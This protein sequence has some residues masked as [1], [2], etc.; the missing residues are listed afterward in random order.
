[1]FS[2]CEVNITV[3]NHVTT[4]NTTRPQLSRAHTKTILK[5]LVGCSLYGLIH[6]HVI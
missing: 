1:M 6:Y 5:L 4:S 2:L 3:L